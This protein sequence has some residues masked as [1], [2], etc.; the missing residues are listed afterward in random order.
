MD[1]NTQEFDP[2]LL[3]NQLCF[4]LY[5]ASKE[6][7]RRYKPFLDPLGLTYTQYVTMM[8]LWE[9][10][11]VPVKDLGRRLY[12]DSATLTPLLKRLETH[13]YVTRRRSAE[14]ERSVLISLT[15]KGWALREAALEVPARIGGCVH[16]EAQ[17]AAELKRLLE[18]LLATLG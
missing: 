8:A 9:R 14:D 2:L 4:P 13:G 6:L 11:D 18:K 12:L 10:D 16:L 1:E 3:S 15:D 17:E 5:V 7:T